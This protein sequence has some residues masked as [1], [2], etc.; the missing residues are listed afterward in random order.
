MFQIRFN[1][2][3]NAWGVLRGTEFV[4]LFVCLND[5]VNFYNAAILRN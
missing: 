4:A 3:L 5:A 1:H 2:P